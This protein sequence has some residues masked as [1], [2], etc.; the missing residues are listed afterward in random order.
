MSSRPPIPWRTG[1]SRGLTEFRQ[2]F[3]PSRLAGQLLWPVATL[4][5]MY[6]FRNHDVAGVLLGSIMFPSVLG[7]FTI[8]GAQLMVQYL[9]AD[10]D[11]GTLLRARSTPLGIPAY[12][13]GKVTLCTMTLMTYLAVIAIP[14]AFI[15]HGLAPM[16]LGR[17]ATL[18]WVLLLGMAACQAVGAVLGAVVP[19]VRAAGYAALLLMGWIAIS[20]VF[21]PITALPAWL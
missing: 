8:F 1:L 2:D 10:R 7:M 11:D 15:V 4:A 19:S 3:A 14:G 13:I 9:A 21:Y 12:L 16:S 18:C 5:V 6:W 17:A 20:G